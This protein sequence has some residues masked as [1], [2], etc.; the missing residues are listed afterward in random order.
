MLVKIWR[1]RSVSF[2]NPIYYCRE[3]CYLWF[4][5]FSYISGGLCLT[6]A[7]ILVF[8]YF[9]FCR[10]LNKRSWRSL[11]ARYLSYTLLYFMIS[12]QYLMN[13]L[14]VF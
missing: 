11:L 5:V 3:S 4:L 7:Y 2:A 1:Y 8:I 10:K 12:V 6:V 13:F 9:S 14:K